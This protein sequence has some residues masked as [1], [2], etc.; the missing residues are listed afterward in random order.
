MRTLVTGGAGPESPS[1]DA[2]SI[3][4]NPVV[5]D[6]TDS[7]AFQGVPTLEF[8]EISTAYFGDVEHSF[9]LI[10]T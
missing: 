9:Q 3:T 10:S 6:V 2:N 5:V 1:P 7:P 8:F 4:S